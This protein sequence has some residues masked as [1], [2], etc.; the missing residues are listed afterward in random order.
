MVGG[1]IF[2][3]SWSFGRC[4]DDSCVGGGLIK[5]QWACPLAK[6]ILASLGRSSLDHPKTHWRFEAFAIFGVCWNNADRGRAIALLVD[7]QMHKRTLI[8]RA[9]EKRDT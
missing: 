5:R 3:E 6:Q 9:N 7:G 1:R 2:V 8:L 4:Y